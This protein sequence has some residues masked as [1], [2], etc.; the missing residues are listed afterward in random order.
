MA[1]VRFSRSKDYR[2]QLRLYN[3]LTKPLT[4]KLRR[5]NSKYGLL[6]NNQL[7][8]SGRLS[9][10]YYDEYFQDLYFIHKSHVDHNK[11]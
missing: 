8:G 6:A 1:K 3:S 5:F 11:K 10:D 4:A 2:E 7:E 9:D